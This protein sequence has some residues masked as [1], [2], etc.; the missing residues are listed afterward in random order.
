MNGMIRKPFDL[1]SIEGEINK[2]LRGR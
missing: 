2:I 1:F